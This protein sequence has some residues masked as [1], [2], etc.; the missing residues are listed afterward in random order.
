MIDTMSCSNDTEQFSHPPVSRILPKSR[1]GIRRPEFSQ[2]DSLQELLEQAGYKETRIFTPASSKANNVVPSNPSAHDE[3]PKKETISRTSATTSTSTPLCESPESGRG[4]EQEIEQ[5]RNKA[6]TAAWFARPWQPSSRQPSTK[7]KSN[8]ESQSLRN[9]HSEPALSKSLPSRR[10]AWNLFWKRSDTEDKPG[11]CDPTVETPAACS[12]S[13]ELCKDSQKPSLRHASSTQHLWQASIKHHRS[14]QARQVTKSRSFPAKLQRNE[15]H[16]TYDG[17]KAVAAVGMGTLPGVPDGLFLRHSR[18]RR[19]SLREAFDT[20]GMVKN[21]AS[22]DHDDSVPSTPEASSEDVHD[23]K[24]RV[25]QPNDEKDCKG[26]GRAQLFATAA[27][28]IISCEDAVAMRNTACLDL[29]HI[30]GPTSPPSDSSRTMRKMKSVDAL[31]LALSRMQSAKE[32]S[33][34]SAPMIPESHSVESLAPED[35]ANAKTTALHV[36]E[37]EPVFLAQE[38]TQSNEPIER[39]TT[40]TLMITSPTGNRDPQ[41]LVLDGVEFEPRSFSPVVNGSK[42]LHR[43]V[44]KRTTWM[45]TNKIYNSSS[46]IDTRGRSQKAHVA[47]KRDGSCRSSRGA[48][49]RNEARLQS[50]SY[51]RRSGIRSFDDMRSAATT[52][53]SPPLSP[54]QQLLVR[55]SGSQQVHAL[56]KSFKQHA[57]SHGGCAAPR[58]PAISDAEDPFNDFVALVQSQGTRNQNHPPF[59]R[60]RSPV[61]FQRAQ[62]VALGEN[63]S[64]GNCQTTDPL[65]LNLK[66]ANE[67]LIKSSSLKGSDVPKG[68]QSSK[69]VKSKPSGI[70]LACLVDMNE[71]KSDSNSDLPKRS[72]DGRRRRGKH[73]ISMGSNTSTTSST[74]SLNDISRSDDE[75]DEN[76]N[77][78]YDSPTAMAEKRILRKR[79]SRNIRG[80]G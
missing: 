23:I 77:P 71:T 54:S 16:V 12:K 18:S 40:P 58:T 38:S 63:R 3:N 76:R 31:E 32:A 73:H 22:D 28:P 29:G 39:A 51:K 48:A 9:K 61:P 67:R 24:W 52:D 7:T 65:P 20:D 72:R 35:F 34:Q 26:K 15:M 64:S 62:R 5:I 27:E 2:F 68:G 21:K 17:A 46:G 41:P 55:P 60:Q 19:I 75:N 59:N 13:D 25:P 37:Q 50:P 44:A 43:P 1:K 69:Q 70:G 53:V 66:H 74:S 14:R 45:T 10:S 57:R 8:S 33:F 36:D 30:S 78:L 47:A 80:H 56:H 42:I 49:S 11:D 79:S 6:S 4:R